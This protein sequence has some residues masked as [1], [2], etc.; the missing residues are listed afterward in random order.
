[1]FHAKVRFGFLATYKETIFLK[2][3]QD[4]KYLG[5]FQSASVFTGHHDTP[6]VSVADKSSLKKYWGCNISEFLQTAPGI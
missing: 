4:R 1:M 2:Q 5:G 3:E 6:S